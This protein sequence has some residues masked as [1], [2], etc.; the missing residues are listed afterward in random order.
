MAIELTQEQI[1][2]LKRELP[3]FSPLRK[4]LLKSQIKEAADTIKY[5]LNAN[6]SEHY[7]DSLI[8]RSPV[9]AFLVR[10]VCFLFGFFINVPNALTFRIL[11]PLSLK[12]TDEYAEPTRVLV[13]PSAASYQ[14][15]LTAPKAEMKKTLAEKIV[16]FARLHSDITEGLTKDPN[17]KQVLYTKAKE[18]YLAIW[19]RFFQPHNLSDIVGSEEKDIEDMVHL[20]AYLNFHGMNKTKIDEL[21]CDKKSKTVFTFLKNEYQHTNKFNEAHRFL[22]IFMLA[23]RMLSGYT[24]AKLTPR[25]GNVL[26]LDEREFH[27]STNE[28]SQH[29]DWIKILME[30]YMG[31]NY[32]NPARAHLHSRPY[33]DNVQLSQYLTLTRSKSGYLVL[34]GLIMG[35]CKLHGE[36]PPIEIL[37]PKDTD[38]LKKFEEL[39]NMQTPDLALREQEHTP[40]ASIAL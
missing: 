23:S 17:C 34:D 3:Y 32:K 14:P 25:L 20:L 6:S 38:E 16:E 28:T 31:I 26:M 9:F 36:K 12:V 24:F 5:I 39:F 35:T 2:T 37:L 40:K 7:S 33:L 21:L 4:A 19:R 22:F 13:E 15:L 11:S 30:Q 29:M 27:D 1:E 8:V 10:I 18:I